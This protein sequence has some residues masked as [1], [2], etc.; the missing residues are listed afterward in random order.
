MGGKYYKNNEFN[1]RYNI[2][3]KSQ[4]FMEWKTGRSDACVFITMYSSPSNIS[5]L[6][7]IKEK[8]I[9]LLQCYRSFIIFLFQLVHYGR[10][11][12]SP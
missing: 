11:R 3:M 1:D 8:I 7:P 6:V 9:L 5:G 10:A 2:C 4:I 12:A